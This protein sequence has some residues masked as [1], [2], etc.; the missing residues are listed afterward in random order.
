MKN[1][2]QIDKYFIAIFGIFGFLFWH[3]AKD[4]L[5][6]RSDGWYVGHVN[7]WG[8][9]AYHLTLINKFLESGNLLPDNPIFA[10]DKINY[11]IFADWSTAQIA[12]FTGVDFALF[13]T[14][15]IVGLILIYI[16]RYFIKIFIKNDKIVFLV[17]LIFFLN[18][19]LGF[20]YFF[21]DYLSSGNSIFNFLINLPRE[22][23]NIQQ[24][25]YWWINVYLA[26]FLP[27]RGFL[28]A[29]PITLTVLILLYLGWQKSNKKFF[30]LAGFLAGILPLV[31][32]HSLFVIFL[33]SLFFSIVTVLFAKGKK[34][35]IL[36]WAIF[37][38]LTIVLALP[39]F[40]VVSSIGNPLKYFRFDPGWTSQENIFWFWFKNLGLFAPMLLI[41]LIWLF[42]KNRQFLIL[43]SP[44]LLI[45]L[46]SNI[47]IFQPWDFDN[48]KL[49]I[50]WFFASAIVV[51]YFMHDL[52]LSKNIFRKI[53]G[54]LILFVMVFSGSLD[55][56][57]TFTKVT[58]YQLFSSLDLEVAGNVKNFT[59][60]DVRFVT[61]SNHN[62]PI[63]VLTGRSTLLGFPGWIWSH[64]ID[65]SQ[66]EI[67]IQKI[68]FGDQEAE[69]L[70][71]QYKVNY[72]TIGPNEKR[73]F[74]INENYFEKYPRIFLGREWAIYDVSNLRTYSNR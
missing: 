27:Q 72:V 66:R 21:Q 3:F 13:I 60:R 31:Q 38:S 34:G 1:L 36:N 9:L 33:I 23:T 10:G 17:L 41:S 45:F 15:F 37:A 58:N 32:A 55:L 44:F 49:L 71:S 70:I 25:G 50:Y 51:A 48:G 20:Y 14:T 11:P 73:S 52:F 64:G 12:R 62:H 5:Q 8:D 6:I 56:F 74:S 69:R 59:P 43:Y 16:S 19:G 68:Y 2:L 26:Y 30:I 7:L 67:D 65:Y 22:Y 61:A 46:L 24:N 63:P 47:F 18:G 29:F 28:F 39:I 42:K 35:V 40:N 4:M 54:V 57:R 53:V